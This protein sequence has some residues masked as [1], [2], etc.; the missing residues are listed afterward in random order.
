MSVGHKAAAR[1]AVDWANEVGPLTPWMLV[2]GGVRSG[3]VR[4]EFLCLLPE[5]LAFACVAASVVKAVVPCAVRSC[6]FSSREC[7][8]LN[9]ECYTY[10]ENTPVALSLSF[11]TLSSFGDHGLWPPDEGAASHRCL[12]TTRRI[13]TIVYM[14]YIC[15]LPVHHHRSARS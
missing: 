1:V 13:S 14:I 8:M 9:T 15:T 11:R 3:G 4:L 5:W 12:P 7:W 10:R 6:L 2:A